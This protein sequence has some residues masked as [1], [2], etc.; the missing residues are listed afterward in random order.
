MILKL[1][2]IYTPVFDTSVY[3]SFHRNDGE[4]YIFVHHKRIVLT[5]AE[6]DAHEL[7]VVRYKLRKAV[8]KCN[9]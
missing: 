5:D 8:K 1:T 3:F 9:L 2:N 6:G 4:N 7:E